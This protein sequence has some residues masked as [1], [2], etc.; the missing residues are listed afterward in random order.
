MVDLPIVGATTVITVSHHPT[1]QGR[2]PPL[3]RH[4]CRPGGSIPHAGACLGLLLCRD[5][6]FGLLIGVGPHLFHVW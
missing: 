5:A 1:A 4:L 2:V 6:C 3:V